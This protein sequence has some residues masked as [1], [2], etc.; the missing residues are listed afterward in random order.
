MAS[1]Q[2]SP[3]IPSPTKSSTSSTYRAPRA[4]RAGVKR[5]M[6]YSRTRSGCLCCRHRRIKCDEKR[7]VCKR[8]IIAKR[9][10]EYPPENTSVPRKR[11]DEGENTANRAPKPKKAKSS[12][13]RK[14]KSRV[15]TKAKAALVVEDTARR[16][17]S[18][19]S[20]HKSFLS[21]S[22]GGNLD[23]RSGSAVATEG[24]TEEIF[25]PA[26]DHQPIQPEQDSQAAGTTELATPSTVSGARSFNNVSDAVESLGAQGS[27][28]MLTAPDYLLPWFSTPQERELILHYAANAAPLMMAIPSGLNPMLAINLPLALACP[29]GT[30][31]ASDALRVAL[32]GTGAIHQ[33]FLL[34]RSGVNNHQ[35]ANMFQFASKLR[36]KGKEMVKRSSM[37]QDGAASDGTLG[38]ITAL[39]SIDI[40]FGGNGWLDN[41]SMAK[42]MVRFRGGPAEMLKM[43]QPRQLAEGVTLSPARMMLEILAIYETFG[44]LT[45]GEEPT[46][47]S[48]QWEEWWSV[49]FST[50]QKY[51][52]E[53]QFGMSRIMVHLFAR[54][55]RLL[56]RVGKSGKRFVL[57][58][59]LSA[60]L[61]PADPLEQEAS[62]LRL[63]VDAWIQH[64]ELNTLDQDRIHVGNRAYALAMRILL[65][66]RVYDV[67]RHDVSIQSA[68]LEVLRYCTVSTAVLNMPIDLVWPAVIAACC[69]A[70]EA[71]SWCLTLLEGFKAQC[72][73][74]ID[75][76]AKIVMESWTRSDRGD[77]RWD[78]KEVCDDLGLKVL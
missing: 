75:T 44:C 3:D 16:S 10:C 41:F 72:C 30:N 18:S 78:W 53:K 28:P 48:D 21:L 64:L 62:K 50:Y 23:A 17:A 51:S 66:R 31:L 49:G 54:L 60:N 47:L 63:D 76:A 27:A 6:K 7:P 39:A 15:R 12:T 42:E 73:F 1:Q 24:V 61:D 68:A 36:D 11:K 5:K 35:T 55:T 19:S 52:V 43:S 2:S 22:A 67:P 71:R 77:A 25:G 8:C 40:F 56:S 4:S 29:K 69:L 45:T 65:L 57:Q 37:S 46:L 14:G 32:L 20:W 74:D 26:A 38:A 34:S 13:R 70:P 33:A 59:T 9:E 58:P